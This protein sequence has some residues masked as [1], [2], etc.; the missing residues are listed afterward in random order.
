MKGRCD[1]V[2]KCYTSTRDPH[3]Q[4]PAVTCRVA[5]LRPSSLRL[6]QHEDRAPRVWPVSVHVEGQTCVCLKH[7]RDTRRSPWGAGDVVEPIRVS[8]SQF[9]FDQ[10]SS[11]LCFSIPSRWD[12]SSF[13]GKS[14]LKVNQRRGVSFVL[15]VD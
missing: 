8:K 14:V 7:L 12:Q 2:R 5:L 6:H 15:S 4:T 9:V 3:S 10:P 1:G 13:R 11:T